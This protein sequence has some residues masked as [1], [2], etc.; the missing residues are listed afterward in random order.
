MIVSSLT[1]AFGVAALALAVLS[2]PALAQEQSAP[3]KYA[4]EETLAIEQV[5]RDY[6]LEHPEVIMEAIEVLQ[7][8]ERIAAEARQREAIAAAG[9]ELYKD[10][11]APVAGNLVLCSPWPGL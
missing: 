10:A 6:L 11:A 1:R 3:Q 9:D 7:E 8:R 2:G 5:V 4:P